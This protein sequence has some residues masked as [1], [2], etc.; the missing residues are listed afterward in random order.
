MIVLIS[1]APLGSAN[2]PMRLLVC[3]YGPL[4]LLAARLAN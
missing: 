4:R 1:L 2:M 3:I